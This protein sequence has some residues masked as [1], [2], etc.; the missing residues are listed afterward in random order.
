M[1]SY[2]QQEYTPAPRKQRSY[3]L[4]GVY[5]GA[6]SG[7]KSQIYP[8]GVSGEKNR[9]KGEGIL[10]VHSCGGSFVYTGCTAGQDD[11]K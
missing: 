2:L 8:S 1:F 7:L 11:P 10:D 4:A 6:F 9:V 3:W 5:S